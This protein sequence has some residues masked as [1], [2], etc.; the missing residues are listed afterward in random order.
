MLNTTV[1]VFTFDNGL[2]PLRG[3]GTA[4]SP[5]AMTKERILLVAR[6]FLGLFNALRSPASSSGSLGLELLSNLSSP[7]KADAPAY[8]RGSLFKGLTRRSTLTDC[9]LG[10]F[11]VV[12]ATCS[13]KRECVDAC[14]ANVFESNSWGQCTVVNEELCFGCMA[15]LAQCSDGGVSVVPNDLYSYARPEDLLK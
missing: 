3:G 1:P 11:T 2:R 8:P 5:L 13:G 7:R 15:C 14:M 6:R 12:V 9:P 10:A 4:I